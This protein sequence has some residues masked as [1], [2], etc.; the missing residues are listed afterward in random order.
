[1]ETLHNLGLYSLKWLKDLCFQDIGGKYEGFILFHT[2][3][4]I[5][6]GHLAHLIY[7]GSQSNSINNLVT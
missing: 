7:T 4:G 2:L 5:E 3:Y 1:M 6:E